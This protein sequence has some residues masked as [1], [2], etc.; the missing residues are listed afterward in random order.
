[1]T[2][3]RSNEPRLGLEG[4]GLILY[5]YLI[6]LARANQGLGARCPLTNAV[7]CQRIVVVSVDPS[8]RYQEKSEEFA[9]L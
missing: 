4:P 2:L 8:R 1:M 3:K 9:A 6:R 5:F 7:T